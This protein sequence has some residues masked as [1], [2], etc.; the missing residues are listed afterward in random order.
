MASNKRQGVEEA[1]AV[2]AELYATLSQLSDRL[3]YA[4]RFDD[5]V[6]RTGDRIREEKEEHPLSF[7]LGVAGVA[8]AVGTLVWWGTSRLMK[9]FT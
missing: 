5:A 3:N 4:Q 6:T 1:D 8:A 9:K 2:R 7:A